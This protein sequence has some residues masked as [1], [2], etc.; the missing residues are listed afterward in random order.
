MTRP[1]TEYHRDVLAMLAETFRVANDNAREY[2]R[3]YREQCD[4]LRAQLTR[5]GRWSVPDVDEMY[6]QMKPK[7]EGITTAMSRW[8]WWTNEAARVSREIRTETLLWDANVAPPDPWYLH[9]LT[10]TLMAARKANEALHA[11]RHRRDRTAHAMAA[12][13]VP[14][15]RVQTDADAREDIPR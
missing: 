9:T 12:P 6:S 7:D 15:P 11:D 4:R 2:G 8:T 3:Q 13:T 5:A 14:M 10:E 1:P